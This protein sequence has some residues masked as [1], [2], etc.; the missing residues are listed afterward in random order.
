[1]SLELN[2]D[3]ID[4]AA[5]K[6][7]DGQGAIVDLLNE[8]KS[9]VADLTASGFNT[10]KASPQFDEDYATL[11]DELTQASDAIGQMSQ[12]LTEIRNGFE[13]FD[14]QSAGG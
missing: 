9:L 6:L 10:E 14:T 5:A 1:M 7:T 3:D 13:E 2:Y 12:R 8:L 4:D 11:T